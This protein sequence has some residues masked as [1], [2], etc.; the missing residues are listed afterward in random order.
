M[1]SDIEQQTQFALEA[2]AEYERVL[3]YAKDNWPLLTSKEKQ[4][5]ISAL[6]SMVESTEG[7][8]D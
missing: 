2:L 3:N 6:D 5:I 4:T 7:L 8:A 1:K